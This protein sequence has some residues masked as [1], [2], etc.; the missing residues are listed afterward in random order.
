MR[1]MRITAALV[2][3]GVSLETFTPLHAT[4]A[5]VNATGRSSV[6]TS[7]RALSAAVA[8][9]DA[10]FTFRRPLAAASA[11][12]LLAL[13]TPKQPIELVFSSAA[14]VV[15]WSSVATAERLAPC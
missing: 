6:A 10:R 13:G 11:H 4:S 5:D 3:I 1:N 9:N 7:E 2:G 14:G 15:G 8:A 12:G